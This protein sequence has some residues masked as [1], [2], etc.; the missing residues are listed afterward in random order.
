MG[1]AANW[2]ELEHQIAKIVQGSLRPIGVA[3]L[4]GEPEGIKK[5]DGTEPSGCSFWRLA[6]EGRTF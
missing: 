2:R 5:F 3:F 4:D 1:L 6:A